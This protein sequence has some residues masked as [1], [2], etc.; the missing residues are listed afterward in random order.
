MIR[1]ATAADI[2]DIARVFHAA[3]H[4]G[5]SPYTNEQRQAW[6]REVRP[7]DAWEQ[8]LRPM[9]VVVADRSGVVG[10]MG[11]LPDGYV[12]LAFILSSERGNGLFR[13]MYSEIEA[14][15]KAK[16]LDHLETHA[17]LMAEPAF[18]AVG[19]KVAERQSVE[20]D[21]ERL[22]RA[23]MKKELT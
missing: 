5:P 19:F 10:F 2:P 18:A 6:S 21:G 14:W 3:I 16:G 12:D 20:R 1:E 11:V 7:A 13:A 15:A 8:R 17:S 4:E 23:K 9:H 22:A